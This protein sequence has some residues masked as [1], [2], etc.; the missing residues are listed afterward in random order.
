MLEQEGIHDVDTGAN[1][2]VVRRM[3]MMVAR[4]KPDANE[5]ERGVR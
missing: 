5:T 1:V 3:G 4:E 2:G